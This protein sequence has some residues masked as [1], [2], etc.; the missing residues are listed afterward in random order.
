MPIVGNMEFLPSVWDRGFRRWADK[1]LNTINSL[2]SGTEFKSFTQLQEQC[3]L[4]SNDLY[5]YFQIRYYTKNHKE[6]ELLSK[7]PNNIEDYFITLVE[8]HLPIKNM[9]HIYIKDF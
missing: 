2:F 8:K 3:Q 7:N 4:P 5:R 9:F 6:R 1:G